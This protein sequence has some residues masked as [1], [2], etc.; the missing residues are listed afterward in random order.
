MVQSQAYMCA[1][2]LLNKDEAD[3]LTNAIREKYLTGPGAVE[4]ERQV[5]PSLAACDFVR[6]IHQKNTPENHRISVYT[7][8]LEPGKYQLFIEFFHDYP[9]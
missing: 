6:P 7:S 8:E 9:N 4:R 2:R 1:D 3:A 5:T